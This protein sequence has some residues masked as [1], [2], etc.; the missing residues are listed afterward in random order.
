MVQHI[1]PYKNEFFLREKYLLEKLSTRQIAKQ[2]FSARSTV[3]KHLKAYGI[4]MRTEDEA[5]DLNN[6]Q[7]AFGEKMLGGKVLPHKGELEVLRRMQS[8][9]NSG[10]S[11]RKIAAQLN[12]SGIPTKN[13]KTKW[14]ATTVMKMLKKTAKAGS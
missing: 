13:R 11:Y 8:L 9:R 3:V 6:G 14:H 10:H 4:P 7:C 5:H 2:V 1:P 12:V